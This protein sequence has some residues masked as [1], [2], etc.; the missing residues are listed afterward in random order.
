[1]TKTGLE[2]IRNT[3][4]EFARMISDGTRNWADVVKDLK[5]TQN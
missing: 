3:P 4:E 1:V 2:P 5:L